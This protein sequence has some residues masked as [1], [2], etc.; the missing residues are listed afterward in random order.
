MALGLRRAGFSHVGLVERDSSSVETLRINGRSGAGVD[1]ACDVAPVDVRAV[2]FGAGPVTLLAAGVPCQPFS[3]GGNHL[4][5]ADERDLF[6]E[7]FR[8]QV[9]MWPDAILIENVLGLARPSFRPYLEYILLQL[10][11]PAL[12]ARKHE[13]WLAH[14]HR[15]LA[16]RGVHGLLSYDVRI[17]AI[18]CAN[19]GVPQRRK[20]L[21]IVAFRTDLNATWGWPENTHTEDALLHAKHQSGRYWAEHGLAMP[22]E[23]SGAGQGGLALDRRGRRWRTVRDVISGLPEPSRNGDRRHHPNHYAIDGARAYHG[24][25]GSRLDEPAKTLKAGVHGVPGGENM[26][27]LDDGSVRYFTV[28]EAAMLQTFPRGYVF[29]GTRGAMI[30]QIGNAAPVKVVDLLGRRILEALRTGAPAE[31][32][33]PHIDLLDAERI[34]RL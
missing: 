1:V 30:R 25:S 11:L 29:A 15:L 4:G 10:A 34:R 33:R 19:F 31:V 17:A 18:E 9:A 13:G 5:S 2:R 6:P 14:K 7:V 8:A 16:S 20:R 28:H 21:F 26:L 32:R 3:F 12:T 22:A 27:V 23:V 24:H